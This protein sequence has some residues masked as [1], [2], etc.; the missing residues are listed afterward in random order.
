MSFFIIFIVFITV[1]IY[2]LKRMPQ[3]TAYII[4]M[5]LG[6]FLSFFSF[7]L[8]L[9]SQNYYFHV[10]N[11]IFHINKHIW[12]S[13]VLANL[14]QHFIIRIFNFG[15]CTLTYCTLL[16][17]VSYTKLYI[18]TVKKYGLHH[19]L[20][21]LMLLEFLLFDPILY[22][23]GLFN[24]NTWLTTRQLFWFV[25][26]I[27]TP[28]FRLINVICAVGALALLFYQ[29][30]S[31]PKLAYFK[32]M[33]LY[34]FLIILAMEIMN[35][36]LF[37][38]SPM[39]LIK[40]SKVSNYYTYIVPDLSQSLL[41][42]KFAPFISAFLLGLVLYFSYL[43]TS[44]QKENRNIAVNI[45][46]NMDTA[47]MGMRVFSHSIKNQL[48][49]IRSET[50]Y[51]QE[52][53]A[54]NE[55]AAYSLNLIHE[56]CHNAFQCLDIG[57]DVLRDRHIHLKYA[58][59]ETAIEPAVKKTLQ[60]SPH[61]DIQITYH[62]TAPYAFIDQ[63]HLTEVLINILQ[64]AVDAINSTSDVRQG[65]IMISVEA[66]GNWLTL[67]IAD[68]GCG[69]NAEECEKIFNPFFSTKSSVSNW[70]MGLSFCQRIIHAHSG[71][72]LVSSKPD[73]GTTF[74]II[75]PIAK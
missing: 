6:W 62:T 1:F 5:V 60:V 67:S 68:N 71:N 73:I 26:Q 45:T 14:N 9:S 18:N 15:I 42:V 23:S 30:L 48:L 72:I 25:N 64:N 12:N 11:N 43:Y 74:D 17:A 34:N 20:L 35:L 40:A 7:I 41:V 55:E 58:S 10:L 44:V 28:F 66:L 37:S 32:K 46:Q 50:E 39:L 70:G 24:P 63:E 2:S 56:A 49:A 16:Y 36:F 27:A 57:Y 75:L 53:T 65:L 21:C 38:W 22:T 59:L 51:L 3:T 29:Y 13:L 33:S 47:A 52:L 8:Y 69:M 4:G 31:G 61:I 54:G 19:I